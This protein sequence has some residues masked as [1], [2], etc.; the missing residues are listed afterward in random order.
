M[1]TVAEKIILIACLCILGYASV[2][3]I[4]ILAMAAR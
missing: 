3:P 4:A 2:E 1:T